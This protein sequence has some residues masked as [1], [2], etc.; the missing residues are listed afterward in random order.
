M[1][2]I[3]SSRENLVFENT[4]S[5]LAAVS[6]PSPILLEKHELYGWNS[7]HP[8][9]EQIIRI[10]RPAL[11]IEVGSWLGA[12]AIHI[13]T[14]CRRLG[15]DARIV[16]VD[17]WLGNV[18]HY[19]SEEYRRSLAFRDGYP[20]LYYG[21]LRNVI[22][23]GHAGMILPLPLHSA[24]G[25]RLIASK[26]LRAGLVYIDG[27]HS[28]A[29][30]LEDL[31]AYSALLAEGGVILGDDILSAGVADAV[32]AFRDED[33]HWRLYVSDNKYLLSRNAIADLD[34]CEADRPGSSDGSRQNARV[35][36]KPPSAAIEELGALSLM[37]IVRLKV[38]G[39]WKSY[40]A[41]FAERAARETGCPHPRGD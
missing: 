17:T 37:Q 10:Q 14:I 7:S 5:Y 41:E 21:F 35:I 31:R 20:T 27:D 25:A 6:C 15:L 34:S 4:A 40:L 36:R 30:C 23:S 11:I 38:S 16:C 13:A 3:D 18:A 33:P 1:G 24:A 8:W 32:A 2:L 29:G 19:Q 26:G 9:F 12:S 22:A 39:R 28:Y